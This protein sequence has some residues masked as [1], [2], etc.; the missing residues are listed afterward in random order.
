MADSPE[1]IG[2][3][4]VLLCDAEGARVRTDQDAVDLMASAYGTEAA[5]VLLPVERLDPDF[6]VLRSGVAGRVLGKFA[7]YRMGLIVVGDVSAQVAESDALRDLLR[8]SNRGR[9][10]WFVADMAEAEQRLAAVGAG[11]RGF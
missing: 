7:D 6:F 1:T 5:W 11:Q 2:G 8:E 9:Q 4:P 3:V 10:A